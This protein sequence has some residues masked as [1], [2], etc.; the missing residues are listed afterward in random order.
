[1]IGQVYVSSRPVSVEWRKYTKKD[2]DQIC[3]VASSNDLRAAQMS[4]KYEKKK[5]KQESLGGK[6]EPEEPVLSPVVPI[7]RSRCWQDN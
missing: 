3:L 1:M 6:K 7:A 5:K 2:V 4:R